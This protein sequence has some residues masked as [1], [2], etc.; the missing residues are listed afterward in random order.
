MNISNHQQSPT[1]HISYRAMS[2]SLSGAGEFTQYIFTFKTVTDENRS[3]H[4]I[5]I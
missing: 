2:F 4:I 3:F 5:F 1:V